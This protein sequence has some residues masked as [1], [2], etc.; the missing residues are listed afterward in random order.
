MTITKFDIFDKISVM[1]QFVFVFDPTASDKLSAVRGI[2][3][4]LQILKE[5]FADWKFTDQ[6]GNC[7][8]AGKAGILDIFCIARTISSRPP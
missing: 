2:G 1:N 7:L 8:P 3:R 5:N 6:I 4:Y